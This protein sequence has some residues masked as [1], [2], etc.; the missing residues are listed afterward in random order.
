MASAKLKRG[1]I[2]ID[3]QERTA[4]KPEIISASRATDIPAY[5]SDW[6]M[7]RLRLGW[8]EWVNPF[9]ANQTQIVSFENTRALVFW[10]KN[11]EP[12]L[13]HLDEL[14][15]RKLNYYFQFTLND[16]QAENLEPGVPELEARI[17]I[18]CTLANRVGKDRVI[19]R[20]DPLLLGSHLTLDILLGR[21]FRLY[22]RLRDA[23]SKLVISFAD[24]A[25]YSAVQRN[26]GPKYRE[27]NAEEMRSLADGLRPIVAAGMEVATCAEAGDFRQ[28]GIRPNRCVDDE[29]LIRLF[30][31]DQ[32]LMAFLR[33]GTRQD[34][35]QTLPMFDEVPAPAPQSAPIVFSKHPLRD[36]GQAARLDCG[37]ILSKDIG[38]YNTCLHLCTYCYANANRAAV[39]RMVARHDPDFP[40]LI[41]NG[42]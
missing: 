8:C 33:S 30:S 1:T 23:T 38:A 14:D 40:R 7:N 9:N 39:K 26:L 36:P 41:G 12:L 5:F 6:L 16:Y 13:Q 28:F 34:A 37:C 3:G 4:V 17:R 27:F 22:E 29:L 10:S 24:I 25:R 19:W 42:T 32:A 11:P 35:P 15:A 21:I 2:L 31:H 20:F 18:F